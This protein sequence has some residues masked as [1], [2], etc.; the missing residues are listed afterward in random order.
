[1]KKES[2]SYVLNIMKSEYFIIDLI[3]M[4]IGIAVLVL[5]VFAFI[6][7]AMETFGVVFILGCAMSIFN[8]IK[9]IMRKSAMG[10]IVFSGLTVAMFVMVSVIYGYFL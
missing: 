1:M 8:M 10:I 2:R 7:G 9:C 3:N 4:V 6:K 5:A